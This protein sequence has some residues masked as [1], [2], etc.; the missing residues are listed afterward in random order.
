MQS[1]PI[2]T[3]NQLIIWSTRLFTLWCTKGS[4]KHPCTSWSDVLIPLAAWRHYNPSRYL[5]PL[6]DENKFL[7][8]AYFSVHSSFYSPPLYVNTQFFLISWLS[9]PLI[10]HGA[11]S[12]AKKRAGCVSVIHGLDRGW[13]LLQVDKKIS[14]FC[15]CLHALC[16]LSLTC[17]TLLWIAVQLTTTTVA[18]YHE[19][20]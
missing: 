18:F 4:R 17:D 8:N 19:E 1:W 10:H 11:P 9:P 13:V 6:R 16:T 5:Q 14:S 12:P 15:H 3:W 2:Q 7:F 20:I